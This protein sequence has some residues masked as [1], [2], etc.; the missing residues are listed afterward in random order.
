MNS[1]FLRTKSGKSSKMIV[2]AQK[3]ND[4]YAKKMLERNYD[5]KDVE[6]FSAVKTLQDARKEKIRSD[7][8]D[9]L[10]VDEMLKLFEEVQDEYRRNPSAI[11]K[12]KNLLKSFGE[13]EVTSEDESRAKNLIGLDDR[14][15]VSQLQI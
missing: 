6:K 15:R 12:K 5:K 2:Y 13:E 10:S 11:E 9:T 8:E 7:P 4:L 14:K 3:V 1:E